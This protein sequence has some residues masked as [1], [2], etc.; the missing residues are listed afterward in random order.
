MEAGAAPRLSDVL[1]EAGGITGK[2]QGVSITL[3][4]TLPDG[5]IVR[6]NADPVALIEGRDGNQNLNVLDGDLITVASQR[7]QT[8]VVSGEVK[9]PGVYELKEGS[10]LPELI[11][12][13]GGPTEDAALRRVSIT[14]RDNT[15]QVVDGF[16][17]IREGGKTAGLPLH[18]GDFVVVPK[19]TARVLILPAVNKPG[20]YP[21]PEGEPLTVG[22]ALALAGGPKERAR[23]KEVAIFRHTSTGVERQII[24]L[25]R[26]SS[27]QLSLDIPLQSGDVLYVPE[28]KQ[29]TSVWNGITSALGGLGTLAAIF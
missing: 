24:A 3:T 9:T 1:A 10:S 20:Y 27:G 11:A 19:N 28:G 13:A 8:V 12:R 22:S 14:T 7:T 23:L 5:Q 6:L 18:D 21:I 16:A 29:S 25:D 26:V 4:R 2:V 17:L 15:T